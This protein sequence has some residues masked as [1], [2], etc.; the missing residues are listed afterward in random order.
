MPSTPSSSATGSLRAFVSTVK[1]AVFL[2]GLVVALAG[3]ASTLAM[4]LLWPSLIEKLVEDLDVATKQDVR[5]INARIDQISGEDKIIRMSPG[6]SFVQEPVSLGEPIELTMSLGRT[7]RGLACNLLSATP[8]FVD[9][10][11][12]PFPGSILEPIIQLRA[13][14]ER[15]K[16]IIPVPESIQTGRVGVYLSLQYSCPFGT[17]GAQVEIFEKTDSI[18]FQIDPPSE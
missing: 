16:A 17:N 14:P 2:A 7:Q 15:L 18:F 9:S 8:L 11:N 10:R 5:E 1:D 12:I 6:L 13:I 3:G 4:K